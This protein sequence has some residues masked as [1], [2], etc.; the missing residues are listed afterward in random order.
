[1][2]YPVTRDDQESLFTATFFRA[3]PSCLAERIVYNQEWK[4]SSGSISPRERRN[5]SVH[6][7]GIAGNWGRSWISADR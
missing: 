7:P 3:T 5:Y 4:K 1:V 2:K 6:R